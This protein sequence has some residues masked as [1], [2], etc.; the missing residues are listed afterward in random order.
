[1]SCGIGHRHGS[2]LV[3]LW[4]WCRPAAIALI[5]PLPWE[6]PYAM[7]VALKDK[8]KKSKPK[9]FKSSKRK[10]QIPQYK[11]TFIKL[12]ADFPA[13]TFQIRREKKKLLK[14]K[15][16]QQICTSEIKERERLSQTNTS[17]GS[18]LPLVLL[19]K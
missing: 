12:Q 14:G 10:K 17:W 9:N 2:D 19:Y 7:G 5:Q 16:I 8:I 6:P 1:M 11:G 15:K 13:E 3:L 18:L 4:L